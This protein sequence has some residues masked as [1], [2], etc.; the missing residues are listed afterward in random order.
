MNELEA[1]IEWA[2]NVDYKNLKTDMMVWEAACEWQRKRDAELITNTPK[3]CSSAEFSTR[4]LTII[5]N[6]R[7]RT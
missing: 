2:R 1:F 7:R 6:Q 4:V 5:T 3:D